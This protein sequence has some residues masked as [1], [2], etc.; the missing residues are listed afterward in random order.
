MLRAPRAA[1]GS[2]VYGILELW[3]IQK[4]ILF[5]I[6]GRPNAKPEWL[7]T[8]REDWWLLYAMPSIHFRNTPY[9]SARLM[10][11]CRVKSFVNTSR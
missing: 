11:F 3:M 6:H 5:L 4:A 10:F 8:C 1:G 2:G 7:G 9:A